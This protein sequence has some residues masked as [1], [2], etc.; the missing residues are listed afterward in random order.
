MK[1]IQYFKDKNK[2]STKDITENVKNL[3]DKFT[4]VFMNKDEVNQQ[5]LKSF[6]SQLKGKF[7]GVI[8]GKNFSGA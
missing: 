6:N 4:E 3:S 7:L 5:F 8:L 1:F 2:K